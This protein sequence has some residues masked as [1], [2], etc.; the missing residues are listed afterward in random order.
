[1]SQPDFGL[2]AARIDALDPDLERNDP[3]ALAYRRLAG[4]YVID[5][6]GLDR[7]LL[8]LITPLA[9]LRW[10]VRVEGDHHLPEVGPALLVHNRRLG[11][12]EPA[13][14]ALAVVRATG[15]P[16]RWTGAPARGPLAQPARQLG[17]V[18]SDRAD[19]RSLLHGGELVGLALAREPFHRYHVP[20]VPPQPVQSALELGVPV[21]PVAVSGLEAAR[22]WSVRI[23]PPI[24]TRRRR[25]IGDPVEL[26]EATREAVRALLTE[27]RREA[28]G[29]APRPT[30]TT[31][32]PRTGLDTGRAPSPG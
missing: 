4:S 9:R 21:V 6:F 29:R 10:R 22:R 32:T 19:V 7:D 17:G 11:L 13:V 14:L 2:D 26:S 8:R 5:E 12:S 31:S 3:A 24:S 20:A 23:G 30:G 18:P 25:D 16:L 27:S 1:M 15:R 28:V